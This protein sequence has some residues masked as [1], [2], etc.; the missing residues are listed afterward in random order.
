MLIDKFL[1]RGIIGRDETHAQKRLFT[2]FGLEVL[3]GFART[4]EH[5]NATPQNEQLRGRKDQ[6][7]KES[8]PVN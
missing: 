6:V 2:D 1:A 5:A 3:N 8:D 4:R 7:H